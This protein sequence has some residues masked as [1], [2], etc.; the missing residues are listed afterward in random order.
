MRCDHNILPYKS[1]SRDGNGSRARVKRGV[2]KSELR[3]KLFV[4]QEQKEKMSRPINHF[5]FLRHYLCVCMCVRR[6]ISYRVYY[7]DGD[8]ACGSGARGRRRVR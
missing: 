3:K 8:R 4:L 1:R 2:W 6:E 7:T 5:D